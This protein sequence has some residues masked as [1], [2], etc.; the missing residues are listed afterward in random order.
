MRSSATTVAGYIEEQPSNW[1]P[2]LEKLRERA[3]AS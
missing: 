1:R 3:V 2:A